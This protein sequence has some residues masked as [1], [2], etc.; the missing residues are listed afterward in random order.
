MAYFGG[1]ANQQSP[2]DWQYTTTNQSELGGRS[3]FWP[4][5]KILGGSSAV[6]G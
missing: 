5:G 3:V 2:Y 6:N 4:R 1:I